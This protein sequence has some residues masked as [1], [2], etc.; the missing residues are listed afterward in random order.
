[1]I[2]LKSRLNN[3]AS[4]Q[5]KINKFKNKRSTWLQTHFSVHF[6]YFNR[7]DVLGFLILCVARHAKNKKKT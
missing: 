5:S 4:C 2:Y 7:K 6:S 1:M 3:K